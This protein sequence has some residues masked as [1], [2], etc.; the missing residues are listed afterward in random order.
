MLQERQKTIKPI[1]Q[2]LNELHL[3]P[4]TYDSIKLLYKLLQTYIQTGERTEV[5]IPFIE[6]NCT[7]RGVLS[8]ENTWVKL[9]TCKNDTPVM[10]A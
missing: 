3:S 6:Y 5:N 9:E 4:I 8:N 10:V 7:I 1:L 2:K